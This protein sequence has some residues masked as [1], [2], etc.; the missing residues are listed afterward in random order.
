[1]PTVADLWILHHPLFISFFAMN[2]NSIWFIH[3]F[4]YLLIY[5]FKRHHDYWCY[6]FIESIS[7]KIYLHIYHFICLD[8]PSWITLLLLWNACFRITFPEHL[9]V[10][11]FL[12]FSSENIFSLTLIIFLTALWDIIYLLLS[13]PVNFLVYL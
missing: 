12:S 10:A 6:C 13:S 1:M 4:I 3:S 5:F 9:L 11:Y 7:V 8:F 2:F